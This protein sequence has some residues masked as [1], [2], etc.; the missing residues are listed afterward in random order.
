[1]RSLFPSE[2]YYLT[3]ENYSAEIPPALLKHRISLLA[4]SLL[5]ES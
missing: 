2:E 4:Q 3:S 5:S 1:M